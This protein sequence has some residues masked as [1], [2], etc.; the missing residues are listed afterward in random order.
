L[1]ESAKKAVLKSNPV[2]PHPPGV[3]KPYVIVGLRFTPKGVK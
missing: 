3:T 1:D 2:R